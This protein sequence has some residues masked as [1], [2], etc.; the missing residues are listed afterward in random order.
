MAKLKIT[1]VKSGIGYKQDQRDT[2][3]SLG[4]HKLNQSVEQED[5]HAIRGMIQKVRHLVK[6]EE[7][8]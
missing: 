5:S 8:Q 7:V 6:V 3:R 4:F 2:L 1:L